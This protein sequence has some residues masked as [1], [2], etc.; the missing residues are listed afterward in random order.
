MDRLKLRHQESI[1]RLKESRM[2]ML[3]DVNVQ[4]AKKMASLE[5]KHQISMSGKFI[6]YDRLENLQKLILYQKYKHF[7]LQ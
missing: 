5:A 2:I 1:K 6:Y 4:H 3:K 7:L